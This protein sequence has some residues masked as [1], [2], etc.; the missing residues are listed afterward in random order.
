MYKRITFCMAYEK[1]FSCYPYFMIQDTH[2]ID[3]NKYF[4]SE[5]FNAIL[6][7]SILNSH[8]LSDTKNTF[9]GYISYYF[10][11]NVI[12]IDD[13]NIKIRESPFTKV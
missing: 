4:I 7:R 6:I 2:S 3:V 11:R 5:I 9:C 10:I 8:T 13:C 12:S 1:H